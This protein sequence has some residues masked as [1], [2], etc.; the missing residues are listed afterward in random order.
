MARKLLLGCGILSS[1][2]YVS[3]DVLGSLHWQGYSVANQTV[4][5]LAAIGS[6]SREIVMWLFTAY[7]VL[8]IAFAS[9][10]SLSAADRID[11]RR[12]ANAIGV[13]G[14]LGVVAAFFPIHV[15]G[16]AWTINE[17]MHSVL[18]AITVFFIVGAIVFGGRTADVRFRAYS[19]ATIA[20]TLGFGAWSGWIGRGLAENLPTPWIGVAERICIYAY[21]A[22]IAAF[23]I[24]LLGGF[25]LFQ[26]DQQ[27]ARRH[28]RIDGM[29]HVGGKAH[30]RAR[31][32]LHAFP[33]D[34]QR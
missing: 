7:N 12:A 28:R 16:Y 21:L 31:A 25:R 33:A 10:I 24:V 20:L 5:E 27:H 1:A 22:W 34:R 14:W 4:S 32:G 2:V 19:T 17:T 13:I 3:A 29:R 30:D 11:L 9:G 8:L 15:R 6:P 26:H 18:T 23:A